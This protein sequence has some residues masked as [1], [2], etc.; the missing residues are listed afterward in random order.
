MS[1]DT[2]EGWH[3]SKQFVEGD[4]YRI[5]VDRPQQRNA[6]TPSLYR[7]VK[8]GVLTAE[9][10]PAI[11]CTVIEGSGG[12]FASGGDLKILLEILEK[13]ERDRLAAFIEAFDESLPFRAVLDCAKPVVAKI[14]GLCLAGG[15]NLALSADIAIA[16]TRSV[17]RLP[18]GLVGVGD[19]FSS[20]LL[21]RSIGLARAR[22]LLLTGATL[23]AEEAAAWGLVLR[24]VP[25]ADLEAELQR[26]LN[27]LRAVSPDSARSYKCALNA[28]LRSV[29]QLEMF[30]LVS[31]D[32]AREGLRAFAAKRPP[33]WGP[34]AR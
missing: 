25:H 7:E 23:S 31:G 15:V 26:V 2:E 17:F 10:D 16:S 30:R 5:V 3:E 20:A 6:F 13:P 18:E 27:E 8:M 22:Y 19:A 32:N 12:V 4:V 9:A 1:I 14:D 29:S 24:V 34:L 33:R 11:R 21:S 28:D